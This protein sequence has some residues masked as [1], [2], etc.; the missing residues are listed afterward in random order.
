MR[1]G[2]KRNTPPPHLLIPAGDAAQSD[3]MRT[4]SDP[5][6][7]EIDSRGLPSEALEWADT[8]ASEVV[9]RPVERNCATV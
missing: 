7:V 9:R 3:Q 4:D 8:T 1:L 6:L 2:A 5:E